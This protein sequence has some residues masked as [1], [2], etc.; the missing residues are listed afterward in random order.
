VRNSRCCD[1]KGTPGRRSLVIVIGTTHAIH[2]RAA[3]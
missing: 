3:G 1:P 2:S